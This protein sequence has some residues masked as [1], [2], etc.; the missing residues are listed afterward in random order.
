LK[1]QEL[2][3]FYILI[4]RLYTAVELHVCPGSSKI[5]CGGGGGGGGSGWLKTILVFRFGPNLFLQVLVLDLDQAE[6]QCCPESFDILNGWGKS[7]V[8]VSL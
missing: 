7:L 8:S 2:E 6:Q 4:L 5:V 1:T 3:Y